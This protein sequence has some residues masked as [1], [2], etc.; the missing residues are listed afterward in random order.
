MVKQGETSEIV[1]DQNTNKQSPKE[2]KYKVY[3]RP[4]CRYYGSND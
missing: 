2:E 4:V 3:F 1:I